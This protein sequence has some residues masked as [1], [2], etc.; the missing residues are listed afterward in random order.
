[1]QVFFLFALGLSDG[2]MTSKS[3]I[4]PLSSE[5]ETNQK[6][7]R[8]GRHEMSWLTFGCVF[9]FFPRLISLLEAVVTHKAVEGESK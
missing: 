9:V 3:Y 7:K 1:M 5:P 4:W 2:D 6:W 8:A